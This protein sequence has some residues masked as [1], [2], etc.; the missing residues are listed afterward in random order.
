MPGLTAGPFYV[1]KS[2]LFSF[3][4]SD[5]DVGFCEGVQWSCHLSEPRYP[6]AA[7]AS[8]SQEL[9]Q[10]PGTRGWKY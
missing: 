5:R 1:V 6:E 3:P 2:L 10:L 8:T 7:E 9:S 4:P